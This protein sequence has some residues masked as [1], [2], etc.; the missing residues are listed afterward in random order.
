MPGASRILHYSTDGTRPGVIDLTGRTVGVTQIVA[1]LRGFALL[2]VAADPVQVLV[3][4]RRGGDTVAQMALP[5]GMGLAHGLRR[6][7]VDS[8]G[9]LFADIGEMNRTR[10]G[11]TIDRCKAPDH[12]RSSPSEQVVW[13]P[14]RHR[15]W[16]GTMP[17]GASKATTLGL[18][19]PLVH[20]RR[21]ALAALLALTFQA[22]PLASAPPVA[23]H[24]P[25]GSVDYAWATVGKSIA[26]KGARGSLQWA[27]PAVCALSNGMG[28]SAEWVTA[29]DVTCYI[30]QDGWLQVGW[31]KDVGWTRPKGFCEFAASS[32]GTGF[33]G[34]TTI[35]SF[36]LAPGTYPYEVTE[37]AGNWYCFV[38]SVNRG[39]RSTTWTGF[40]VADTVR[41][42]G[43]TM[44]FHSTIG[45]MAPAKFLLNDVR[46]LIGG[47]WSFIDFDPPGTIEYPY[48]LDEPASG[49][50]RNWTVSH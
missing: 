5:T 38:N 23:A 14:Q 9:R 17:E 28:F 2:D 24:C 1:A 7:G 39:S 42:G 31:K 6:I 41:A 34:G 13:A 32:G 21:I 27:N 33:G 50:V 20:W 30:G 12:C 10:R 15:T 43:E 49:Q 26:N 16:E 48:G 36:S 29:C 46:G 35:I 25:G 19:R 44:S 8:L 37:A 22:I 45:V 4:D 47:S 40:A 18:A 3:V 11:K